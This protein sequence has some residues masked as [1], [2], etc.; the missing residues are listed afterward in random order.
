MFFVSKVR[1]FVFESVYFRPLNLMYYGFVV[2]FLVVPDPSNTSNTLNIPNFRD[3]SESPTYGVS[4]LYTARNSVP[5]GS[6]QKKPFATHF[7]VA[8]GFVV[9]VRNV[10]KWPRLCCWH[11]SAR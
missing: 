9:G 1:E 6:G 4:L 3:T 7:W 5:T 8:L 2:V 10:P 11:S